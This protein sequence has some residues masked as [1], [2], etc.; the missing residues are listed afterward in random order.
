MGCL[1]N[2]GG[3]QYNLVNGRWRGIRGEGE[4]AEQRSPSSSTCQPRAAVVSPR[5]VCGP[6]PDVVGFGSRQLRRWVHRA[7]AR[8]HT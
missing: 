4:C 7:A 6:G 3:W 5:T 8:Q 2:D 1:R